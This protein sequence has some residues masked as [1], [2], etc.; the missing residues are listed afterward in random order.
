MT[1]SP[2]FPES[3]PY[4]TGHLILPAFR[5]QISSRKTPMVLRSLVIENFAS[6]F[7]EGRVKMAENYLR[8]FCK[9]VLR[10]TESLKS[11]GLGPAIMAS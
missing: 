10:F 6:E 9:E 8:H 5:R 7:R 3:V 11:K 1:E 2:Y 4:F